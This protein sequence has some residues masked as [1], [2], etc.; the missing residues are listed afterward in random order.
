MIVSNA[1]DPLKPSISATAA[2]SRAASPMDPTLKTAVAPPCSTTQSAT[3]AARNSL[4]PCS[5]MLDLPGTRNSG[6]EAGHGRDQLTALV[7]SARDTRPCLIRR[8]RSLVSLL[9]DHVLGWT[10][11]QSGA[12]GLRAIR[13]GVDLATQNPVGLD[14]KALRTPVAPR[15]VA[16]G[17]GQAPCAR[18]A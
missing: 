14:D 9:P 11:A 5:L 8:G 1:P 17:M 7:G 18:R 2:A 6:T 16:D 12:T 4:Q 13:P 10:R 3:P 15:A